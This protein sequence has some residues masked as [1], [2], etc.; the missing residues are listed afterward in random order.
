[1]WLVPTAV[2]AEAAGKAPVSGLGARELILIAAIVLLVAGVGL[3]NGL[4][5]APR[6]AGTRGAFASRAY[7][8]RLLGPARPR[9]LSRGARP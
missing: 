2:M 9:L 7:L 6:P 3:S 1:M 5:R 8:A 4:E